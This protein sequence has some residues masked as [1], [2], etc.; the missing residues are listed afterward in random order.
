MFQ[1]FMGESAHA[2][3]V[4]G[5]QSRWWARFGQAQ[6]MMRIVHW[7]ARTT[8]PTE[9]L[10]TQKC[11]RTH[12]SAG[13]G[14]VIDLHGRPGSSPLHELRARS[15]AGM[16]KRLLDLESALE[17]V[18]MPGMHRTAMRTSMGLDFSAFTV[19][20]CEECG[21]LLKPDVRF[22]GERCPG[23]ESRPPWKPWSAPMPCW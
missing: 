19:P 1:A 23:S 9:V 18:W 6:P 20:D 10:V 16:Q 11:R 2:A 15:G 22:F 5:T 12:Q 17:Q 8:R 4:L 13:S 21:G 14:A 3:Q 7:A